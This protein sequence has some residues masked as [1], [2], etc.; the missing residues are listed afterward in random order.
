MQHNML[1]LAELINTN[2]KEHNVRATAFNEVK[3]G[4]NVY[5]SGDVDINSTTVKA[6]ATKEEFVAAVNNEIANVDARIDADGFIIFSND[7]GYAINFAI[8]QN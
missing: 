5:T 6:R 4:T 8:L 2:T 1:S 7:S 3:A